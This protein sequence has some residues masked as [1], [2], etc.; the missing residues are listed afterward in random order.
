M[1]RIV[2]LDDFAGQI[3]DLADA[4]NSVPIHSRGATE[5]VLSH[6][7]NR[8]LLILDAHNP[9]GTTSSATNAVANDA[10]LLKDTSGEEM[11]HFSLRETIEA[12]EYIA[13]HPWIC[14]YA[15][16]HHFWDE[17]KVF[18]GYKEQAKAVE[19]EEKRE[20]EEDERRKEENIEL[21]E[22]ERGKKNRR[23]NVKSK[24]GPSGR[25]IAAGKKIPEPKKA[26]NGSQSRKLDEW[27]EPRTRAGVK[28][29]RVRKC[30]QK[31]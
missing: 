24:R 21:G 1:A 20:L 6:G 12:M 13:D 29:S 4:L 17:Y 11:E 10:G 9:I 30:K 16:V 3:S 28:K 7:P 25:F 18:Q 14:N 23:K 8:E 5:G 27:I 31:N 22:T 26:G 15:L 2:D 19:E